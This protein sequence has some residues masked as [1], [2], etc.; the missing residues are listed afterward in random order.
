[1]R[2]AAVHGALGALWMFLLGTVAP[3]P[4][5]AVVLWALFAVYGAWGATVVWRRTALPFA[6]ASALLATLIAALLAGLAM[7]GWAFPALP[8]GWT[9]AIVAAMF[10]GPILLLV[11]S[12]VHPLQWARWKAYAD[13][14]GAWDILLGRHVP[15]LRQ[16]H[17]H[18][19]S[20]GA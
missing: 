8:P 9:V 3:Q 4:I 19:R 1:M 7:R 10:L 15:D 5:G 12:K 17:S 13:N 18:G 2:G 11:E 14:K 20:S 16:S 6:T